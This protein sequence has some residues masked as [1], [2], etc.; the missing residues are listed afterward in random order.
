M[1]AAV[2]RAF[3]QLSRGILT[4]TLF[5]SVDILHA[6]TEVREVRLSAC[7][8]TAG[9]RCPGIISSALTQ[10]QR[11]SPARVYLLFSPPPT[12]SREWPREEAKL[13]AGPDLGYH[14]SEIISHFKR[15]GTCLC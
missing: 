6:E 11:S 12:L 8:Y 10:S 9:K 7:G 13:E 14:I 15:L 5:P 4:A 2:L 1:L 3:S